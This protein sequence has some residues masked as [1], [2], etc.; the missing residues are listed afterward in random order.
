MP[1]EWA[2]NGMV[3][4]INRVNFPIPAGNIPEVLTADAEGRFT[5]LLTAVEVAGLGETLAGKFRPFFI[6]EA[7]WFFLETSA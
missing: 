6:K 7:N 3:Q 1:D 2:D 5:T 4:V